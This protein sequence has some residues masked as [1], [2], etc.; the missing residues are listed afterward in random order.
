MS[1]VAR[2]P[3]AAGL[4]MALLVS[5]LPGSVGAQLPE[6]DSVSRSQAPKA[7]LRDSHER[8][9]SLMAV[10]DM[11]G[12]YQVLATRLEVVPGD[13]EALWRATRAALIL[14]ILADDRE[15]SLAW[16]RIADGYGARLLAGRPDD[17]EAMAWAAAAR[18]LRAIAESGPRATARLSNE[19]WQI[20]E[21][22]L[23]LEPGHPLGN[24]VRGK[25]HYEV[26]RLSKVERWFGRV[27]LGGDA[28]SQASWELA[29]THLRRA[30]E[31]DP[32]M[33]LFYLDLGDAYRAQEKFPEAAEAFRRGLAVPD[34]YPM[35]SKLKELIKRRIVAMSAP[36][37]SS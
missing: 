15:E 32:G 37:G 17:A 36:A 11:P 18:G 19:V 35:D 14:G 22:L 24:D 25:L 13:P 23:A 26:M 34:R 28:L 27:F 2:T 8:A 12:A 30:V 10:S 29:E 4:C 21:R 16:T 33:V 31:A 9:D 3:L 6:S 20:T 1:I 5:A 7:L